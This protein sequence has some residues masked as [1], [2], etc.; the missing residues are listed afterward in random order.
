MNIY[1]IE[2]NVKRAGA[3]L[4]YTE[5]VKAN[6]DMELY[7]SQ[8]DYYKILEGETKEKKKKSLKKLYTEQFEADWQQRVERAKEV[9]NVAI[10]GEE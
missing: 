3:Y 10:M 4:S 5:F 8:T 2:Q 1:E 7:V 9:I 6:P